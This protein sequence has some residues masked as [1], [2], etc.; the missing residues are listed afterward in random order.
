MEQFHHGDHKQVQYFMEK[1]KK[2]SKK[3][4]TSKDENVQ[5]NKTVEE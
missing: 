5:N 3:K 2:A 4:E 1:K